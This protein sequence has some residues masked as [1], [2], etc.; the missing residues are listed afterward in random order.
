MNK[1]TKEKNWGSVRKSVPRHESVSKVTGQAVYT[2]DLVIPGWSYGRMLRSPY[3][4]A[5]VL[6]IDKSKG[7]KGARRAGDPAAAGCSPEKIQQ[8]GKPSFRASGRRRKDPH[9][10]PS[11]HGGPDRGRCGPHPGGLRRGASGRWT[12]EYEPLPPV[13]DVREALT[14]KA[15]A[16]PSRSLSRQRVQGH[17][18]GGGGR[19][20]GAGR[21]R[22]RFRT[23]IRHAFCAA[24]PHGNGHVHLPLHPR[25]VSDRL[26]HHP[27]ALSRTA[28]SWRSSSTCRRAASVSSNR[29]W[30]GASGAGSRSTTS[31]SAPCFRKRSTA[32]SRSSTAGRRNCLATAVRHGTVCRIRCGVKKDGRLHAFDAEVLLNSGAYCTH[33]PI[34]SAAQSRKFQYRIPELPLQRDLRVHERAGGRRHAGIRQPAAHLRPGADDGR[35]R[36]DPEDGPGRASA[37]RIISRSASTFPRF[38]FPCRAARFRNWWREGR[39]SAGRSKRRR[40]NGNRSPGW[41][42][43]GGLLFPATPP[44]PPTRRG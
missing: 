17:R 11:L 10:P 40:R 31:T 35:D 26:G 13:F 9:R 5:R 1:T 16:A 8:R 18:E 7:R 25:R 43:P 21:V 2:D 19:G 15:P 39:R 14:E 20:E 30:A 23:G 33:G 12:V 29:P 32:R 3:A 44:A 34:I 24:R 28:G 27:D 22:F 37:S 36:Q 38:P 6:R 42:K 4:H 41:W